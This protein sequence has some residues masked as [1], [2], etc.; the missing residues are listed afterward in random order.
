V[1][2]VHAIKKDIH[3]IFVAFQNRLGMRQLFRDFFIKF[4]AASRNPFWGILAAFGNSFVMAIA[5][6]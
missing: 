1:K 6:F 5:A 3:G 2:V 4:S